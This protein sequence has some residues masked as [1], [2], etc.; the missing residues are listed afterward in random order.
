MEVI[1]KALQQYAL[2]IIA[3]DAGSRYPNPGR[4]LRN[5]NNVVQ[6]T[7]DLQS[8]GSVHDQMA[9][10]LTGLQSSNNSNDAPPPTGGVT[11]EMVTDAIDAAF[12]SRGL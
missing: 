3:K 5:I 1:I 9:T 2:C 4:M 10:L 7:N 11:I 6:G 12:T 8:G